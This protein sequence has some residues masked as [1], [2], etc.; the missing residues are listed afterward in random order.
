MQKS[1]DSWEYILLPVGTGLVQLNYSPTRD[2]AF[3][4]ITSP[5]FTTT[6]VMMRHRDSHSG[7]INT[8]A[9]SEHINLP[10]P[11]E[12]LEFAPRLAFYTAVRDLPVARSKAEYKSGSFQGQD[13]K[14]FA[15]IAASDLID[16]SPRTADGKMENPTGYLRPWKVRESN[17]RP[18]A[19]REAIKQLQRE[20]V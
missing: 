8:R 14:Y 19:Y 13:D 17:S 1:I 10:C 3:E 4:K 7:Q 5:F 12:K 6:E 11:D 15:L 20:S 16:I 2:T 18:R 9:L